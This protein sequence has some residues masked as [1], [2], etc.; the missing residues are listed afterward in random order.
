MLLKRLFDKTFYFGG[1][2]GNI[3]CKYA[4]RGLDL[5]TEPDK[6]VKKGRKTAY[7]LCTR[8]LRM[9]SRGSDLNIKIGNN[10]QEINQA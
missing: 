3:G 8:S 1:G 10:T 5:R 2:G 7:V 9:A 6:G 4:R